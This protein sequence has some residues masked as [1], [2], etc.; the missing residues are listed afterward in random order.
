MARTTKPLTHTQIHQAKPRVK[1]FNLVDGKN[2]ALRVKPNASKLWVFTYYRPLTKKRTSISLGAFPAVSLAEARKKADEVRTLLSRDIDPKEHRDEV[3]MAA[4]NARRHT[5]QAVA[6]EWLEVKKASISADHA[7]DIWRSLELHVFP[8]IGNSPI[9]ALT[10][11]KAIE[12]LKPLGAKGSLEMVKRVCQRLNEVMVFALNTGI[13]LNNPLSGI[14]QA[15]QPPSKRHLPTLTPEELPSLLKS[16]AQASIRRTTRR[17]LEWQLHTMVR[18]GEAAG[19]RW[20]EIDL[21]RSLW[22]IPAIRMKQKKEHLVP[23]TKQS[24]SILEAMRPISGRCAFVFPSDRDPKKPTN[25]ATANMAVKR[26]GY[27]K[28]LVAHGLRS[29]ASTTLNE[30][31]F[32]PDVIE[33][34]LSH[35]SGDEVRNAY[36]RAHYLE[37]RRSLMKWWSDHI[38]NSLYSPS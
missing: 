22:T 12:T 37:R 25:P 35:K 20:D 19:T 18:P 8:T 24:I 13:I 33:A 16:I 23:L 26:M 21:E 31:G 30:E 15:F 4:I 38:H 17:L 14:R 36:N 32:H 9:S 2:L 7:H 29:L 1:E 27:H 28:K 3:S 6:K 34:A 5:L 10:A 11:T